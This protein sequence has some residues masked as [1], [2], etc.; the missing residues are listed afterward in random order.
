MGNETEPKFN[1]IEKNGFTY[2]VPNDKVLLDT[3]T[4]PTGWDPYLSVK[5][6]NDV[7]VAGPLTMAFKNMS[8]KHWGGKNDVVKPG[9]IV[10]Y[11]DNVYAASDM[12]MRWWCPVGKNISDQGY[13]TQN[14]LSDP[15]VTTRGR[16]S[17]NLGNNYKWARTATY[18]HEY[19]NKEAYELTQDIEKHLTVLFDLWRLRKAKVTRLVKKELAAE[20][21]MTLKEY[22]ES[23]KSDKQNITDYHQ[24]S[25]AMEI[26]GHIYEFKKKLDTI[27][28]MAMKGKV[29]KKHI[30]QVHHAFQEFYTK[31]RKSNS[32]SSLKAKK[33]VS[34][35]RMEDMEDMLTKIAQRD[36]GTLK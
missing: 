11:N 9:R 25:A 33:A 18:R 4:T 34:K 17:Y 31:L 20:S 35:L 21:N 36:D 22:S 28:Q 16:G 26:S 10:V 1:L 7:I 12:M 19:V 14:Q 27:E 3:I 29:E 8:F 32:K 30:S 13:R 5:G 24:T 2:S 23:L 6:T 15:Y